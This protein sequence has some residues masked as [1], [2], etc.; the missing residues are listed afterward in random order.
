LPEF[1]IRTAARTGEVLG[2]TWSEIDFES[3]L[4]TIPGRRRKGGKDHRVPLSA[5]ALAIPLAI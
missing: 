5:P 2:A 1:L 4:W 3:R